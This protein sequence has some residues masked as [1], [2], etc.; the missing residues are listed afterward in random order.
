MRNCNRPITAARLRKKERPLS[1][2]TG[3][4]ALRLLLLG[5][6]FAFSN[7]LSMNQGEMQAREFDATP[8]APTIGGSSAP[9]IERDRREK[10]FDRTSGFQVERQL[11]SLPSVKAQSS[12]PENPAQP[13][14]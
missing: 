11:M 1:G 3:S 8:A 2:V 5:A 14:A 4:Q 9:T 6:V 7:P 10:I 12:E 13:H